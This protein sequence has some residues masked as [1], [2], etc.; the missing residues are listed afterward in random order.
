MSEIDET[1]LYEQFLEAREQAIALSDRFAATP[2]T[3]PARD[4]LWDSVLRQTETARALLE[5]WLRMGNL[6][7]LAPAN[8][9]A[10]ERQRETAE[11]PS[12]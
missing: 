4:E 12:G 11:Q 1:I 3:D 6:S 8:P 2:K 7:D 9:P 5:R 10:L